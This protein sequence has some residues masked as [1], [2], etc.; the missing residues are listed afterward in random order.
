MIARRAGACRRAA[1]RPE[2]PTPSGLRR[3]ASGTATRLETTTRPNSSRPLL[4]STG[5]PGLHRRSPDETACAAGASADD[6]EVVPPEPLCGR[7][8][9]RPSIDVQG[10]GGTGRALV[11]S[12]APHGSD[13]RHSSDRRRY[14]G[15]GSSSGIGRRRSSG[16][17]GAWDKRPPLGL[18][19][20]P[21]GRR[22]S[23]GTLRPG[24][25]VRGGFRPIGAR[26]ADGYPGPCREYRRTSFSEISEAGTRR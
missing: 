17:R 15:R 8:G 11:P 2:N 22:E 19:R 7:H 5:R 4:I 25:G 12:A 1:T 18:P 20:D 21:E 24:A 16:R 3:P 6:T 9:G 10:E 14:R 13:R 23:S 26:C